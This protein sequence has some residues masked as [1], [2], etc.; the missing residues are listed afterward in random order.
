MT[1]EEYKAAVDKVAFRPDFVP[2]TLALLE[3]RR[4][5]PVSM[6]KI[7]LKT[8]L[9]AAALVA[10]LAITASAAVL[11]LSP[12]EVAREAGRDTLAQAFEGENAVAIDQA[13][14]V[15]DYQVT[16]MGMLPGAE[17]P[18]FDGVVDTAQTYVV[19]ACARTDGEPITDAVPEV[20]ATPLVSG[21]APWLLNAW[22]LSGGATSFT[23][24]GVLYYLFECDTLEPFA[25][26]EVYLAVYP[27]THRVPSAEFFSF[28]PDG[29]IAYQPDQEGVLFTL[30]LDPAKAD[31]AK[32]AEL[33]SWD[34]AED[35]PKPEPEEPGETDE[36]QEYHVVEKHTD[37]DGASYVLIEG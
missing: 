37:G 36:T 4:K 28:G 27:G 2:R 34:D 13:E 23:Q 21:Y 1:S 32:A 26:H 6:K 22:T 35:E 9:V 7:S 30:P 25:D 3:A 33:A 11:F 19:L 18:E 10:A 24:D 12:G 31:P 5:E 29:A 20:T 15:G 8:V 14:T 16:L 17:L